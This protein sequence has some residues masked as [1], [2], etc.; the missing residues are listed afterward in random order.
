MIVVL[1]I[2]AIVLIIM[3]FNSLRIVNE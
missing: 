2:A 1:P 3:V